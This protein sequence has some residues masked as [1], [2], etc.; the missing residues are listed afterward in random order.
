MECLSGLVFDGNGFTEGYVCVE[1]GIITEMGDG[2]PPVRPAV[3]GI[4]TPGLVNAHTHSAD[5]LLAFSGS[6]KLEEL[7]MPPDGMKHVYLRNASD[8]ELILSM[9]SFTDTMFSTGTTGFI[10]F[11]EGGRRGAELMRISSPTPN[12]MILGRPSGSYDANEMDAVLDITDGIGISGISD[13]GAN[14]LDAIADHV[15]KRGKILGIHVSERAR[16]DIG[17]VM[18]LSPSFV[19]HMVCAADSDMRVCADNAIPIVSCPRS[20]MFFGRVP[21]LDRMISSGADVAIGTDN[22]MLCVP[23]MRAEARTFLGILEKRG[24]GTVDT[25][26]SLLMNCRKVL[27]GGYGL[28]MRVGMPADIAVFRSSGR[29]AAEDITDA[30]ADVVMTLLGERTWRPE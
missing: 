1:N 28:Q 19:V 20:N 12:G 14:E 13:M 4:I 23:D 26:R 15:R 7:V 3:T 17:R 6:P 16:E 9:R 21:P 2:R 10:D 24:Y 27:Y 8:D 29:G 22:A 25:I 5:G 11:R 30:G 18:S